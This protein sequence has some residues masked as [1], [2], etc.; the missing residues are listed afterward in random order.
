MK[1][2]QIK[3]RARKLLTRGK[4]IWIPMMRIKYTV[5]NTQYDKLFDAYLYKKS[6]FRLLLLA[7]IR[8]PSDFIFEE[9][10]KPK[11]YTLDPMVTNPNEIIND[12]I[13]FREVLIRKKEEIDK[14]IRLTPFAQAA[15][16]F[17]PMV[18][19]VY[20]KPIDDLWLIEN[21]LSILDALQISPDRKI[22]IISHEL[23]FIPIIINLDEK[24]AYEPALS[25][26][27]S[28]GITFLLSKYKIVRKFFQQLI[29]SLEYS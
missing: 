14:K 4:L 25:T 29:E 17:I 21:V 18:G 22:N 11:K 15:T 24:K 1:Y 13:E 26:K 12:L 2:A 6:G 16:L 23:L 10:E 27:E 5:A 3:K 28:K 8:D 9:V 20:S 7:L 19:K